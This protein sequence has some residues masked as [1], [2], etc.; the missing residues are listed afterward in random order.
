M[1]ECVDALWVEAELKQVIGDTQHA[2]DIT[3]NDVVIFGN[4]GVLFAGPECI[5]HETLLLAYLA[6]KSRRGRGRGGSFI[7]VVH[8]Y[9]RWSI[10]WSI[11]PFVGPYI[12]PLVLSL[13]HA[14]LIPNGPELIKLLNI[15]PISV[16]KKIT[17]TFM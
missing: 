12:G 13:V 6:L 4:A 11:G 9:I 1:N 16:K 15:S 3:E 10:H 14:R 5:R 8:W 17:T 7:H 2:F